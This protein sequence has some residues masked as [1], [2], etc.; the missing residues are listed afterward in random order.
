MIGQKYG[1][2]VVLAKAPSDPKWGMSR[3][4]CLCE[5]GVTT[6]VYGRTLRNSRTPSCGC[7]HVEAISK[8]ARKYHTLADYL[9]NTTPNGGCLEWLGH[10]DKNGY[11]SAGSYTPKHLPK[12]TPLV[13]RRV[14][15]EV[16][17]YYPPIVMHTCD[18]RKCIN[19]KH[20]I[21]GTHKENSQDAVRKGRLNR[22]REKYWVMHNGKRIGLAEFS[23]LT[24]TPMATLQWRARNGKLELIK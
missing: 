12:R 21:A 18:N 5:C 24:G 3:W 17:K 16:N 10:L 14:F 8:A 7:A 13:H 19:P 20:L 9:A 22:G 4:V 23:R 11:G 6:E 2:L 1:R 15:Y